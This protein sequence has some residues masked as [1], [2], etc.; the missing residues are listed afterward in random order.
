MSA[1]MMPPIR[2]VD[3]ITPLKMT[4]PRPGMYVFDMG[5]N[6]SGWVRLRVQGP[7]GAAVR[8]RHAE[9]LYDDGTLNVEN[10]RTAKATDVYILRGERGGGLRAALH[11]PRLPL[12]G[13]DAVSGD[14]RAGRHPGQSRPHGRHAPPAASRRPS[15]S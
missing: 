3:T 13:G 10:L 4:S 5:Q 1:Q 7:Q 15:R 8:L 2:V 9:L 6:F 14:A 11:L 12:R